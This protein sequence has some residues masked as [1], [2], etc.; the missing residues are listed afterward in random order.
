M[1]F[2]ILYSILHV[3]SVLKRYID[4]VANVAVVAV[5]AF[6]NDVAALSYFHMCVTHY[7]VLKTN[8]EIKN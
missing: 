2:L 3:F 7:I 4:F 1:L 6:V 8:L 5:V